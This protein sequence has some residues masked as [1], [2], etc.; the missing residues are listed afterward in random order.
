MSAG[1]PGILFLCVANSARSQMAEGLARSFFGERARVQSAGSRPSR[2]NPYAI[3][4]MAELGISLADAASKSV[5]LIDPASVD[6]VITLCAEE[7]CPVF[8]GAARRLHWP[9]RDPASIDPTLSREDML[10]R[11]RAAR[12]TIRAKLVQFAAEEHA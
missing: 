8:L 3:E 4:V 11:F 12:D 5:E 10:E 2:V 9:V 7:V 6:L 1:P